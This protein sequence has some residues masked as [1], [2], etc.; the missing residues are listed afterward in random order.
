MRKV[1]S[2]AT[3]RLRIQMRMLEASDFELRA[4]SIYAGIHA[5]QGREPAAG[6]VILVAG[7][8]RG[9]CAP[10]KRKAISQQAL[11]NGS[12]TVCTAGGTSSM[13]SCEASSLRQ[14]GGMEAARRA[15]RGACPGLRPSP[16]SN[17]QKY[18]PRGQSPG[19]GHLASG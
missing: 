1:R 15:M 13:R 8:E 9:S 5:E 10:Q 19:G 6:G 11:K 3:C 4:R 7:D 16:Q 17:G 2:P 12:R 14:E 18:S